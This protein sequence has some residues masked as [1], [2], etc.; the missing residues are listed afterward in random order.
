MFLKYLLFD[1]TQSCPVVQAAMSMLHP[2]LL[3]QEELVNPERIR[4]F[5]NAQPGAVAPTLALVA[6]DKNKANG[7][8]VNTVHASSF[9]STSR[10]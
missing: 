5:R 6:K 1:G 9:A 2:E 10:N 4:R 8:L 7:A 3:N